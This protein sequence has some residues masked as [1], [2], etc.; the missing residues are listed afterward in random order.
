[1]TNVTRRALCAVLP[2]LA[3]PAI[4][5]A[6]VAGTSFRLETMSGQLDPVLDLYRQ[7]LEA[8]RDWHLRSEVEHDDDDPVMAELMGEWC[9]LTDEIGRVGPS[10]AEGMAAMLHVQ[11]VEFGP[12][13]ATWAERYEDECNRPENAF[14][15][16]A[17]RA[18]TGK[19]GWP[20]KEGWEPHG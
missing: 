19:D 3:L 6:A 15:A 8:R 16:H 18:V 11:W 13:G 12:T 14:I 10:S 9:R 20:R 17:W 7:W 1:M 5:V 4:P 2:A